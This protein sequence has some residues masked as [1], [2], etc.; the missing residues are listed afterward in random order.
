MKAAGIGRKTLCGS[1]SGQM[2]FSLVAVLLL[3]LSGTSIALMYQE[4]A[5]REERMTP[6]TIQELKVSSIQACDDISRTAYVAAL[7]ATRGKD[8]LN[9]S[10]LQERFL[11]S[12][13]SALNDT[14]PGL[15]AGCR[16]PRSIWS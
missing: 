15:V 5:V 12:L 2:P 8:V 10:A 16:S 14:Y 3:V 7:E 1:R 13:S 11:R 9:A 4:D 6:E